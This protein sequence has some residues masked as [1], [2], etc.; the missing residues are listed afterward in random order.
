MG[1]PHLSTGDHNICIIF[2][3]SMAMFSNIFQCIP[4]FYIIFQFSTAMSVTMM[5]VAGLGLLGNT[6]SVFVLARLVFITITITITI[7]ISISITITSTITITITITI[8]I[9]TPM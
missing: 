1:L 8:I 2:Q 7:T 3:F 9:I 5:V 6:F 4:M